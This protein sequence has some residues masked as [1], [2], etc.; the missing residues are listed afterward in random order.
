M[1]PPTLHTGLAELLEASGIKSQYPDVMCFAAFIPSK[2]D[3]VGS[4]IKQVV[5]FRL[6]HPEASVLFF[7]LLPKGDIISI[8]EFRVL[9]L[10][11][12]EFIHLPCS[13]EAIIRAAVQKTDKSTGVNLSEWKLFADKACKALLKQRILELDHNKKIPVGNKVLNPLRWNCAVSLSRPNLKEDC[14]PLLQKNFEELHRFMAIPDIVELL[15]WCGICN[16]SDDMYLKYAYSFASKLQQL[17]TYTEH[18]DAEE[19]ISLIDRVNESF[20]QLL[21]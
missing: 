20:K 16:D 7:S 8:D 14:L 1:S 9:Q 19:I 4:G 6:L 2:Q 3:V 15:H 12:T 18:T 11:G 10:A 13:K 5:K 17:S 21:N